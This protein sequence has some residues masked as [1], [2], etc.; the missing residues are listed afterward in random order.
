MT[1]LIGRNDVG[2]SAILDALEIFFNNET[3]KIEPGDC[4][5]HAPDKTVEIT[6]E[7]SDLPSPL[8]LDSQAETRL[9]EEFLL[10]ETERLRIKK[11]KGLQVDGSP[12]HGF[13]ARVTEA[14]GRNRRVIIHGH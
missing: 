13:P 2:K 14:A 7:F 10:T 9:R 11:K 12:A 1:A 6:C 3:V 5:V 8:V 4:N